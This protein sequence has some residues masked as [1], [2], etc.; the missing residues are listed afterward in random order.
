MIPNTAHALKTT[1]TPHY[2]S[3]RTHPMYAHLQQIE[4]LQTFMSHHVVA[5]WDFMS[6][7]KALQHAFTCTTWPWRPVGNPNIRRMLNEIVLA[8][9]SDLIDGKATSHFEYYCDAMRAIGANTAPIAHLVSALETG[10][11]LTEALVTTTLPPAAK[12]F[13]ETTLNILQTGKL[14][15]I[16]AAFALGR[17]DVIP[18]MFVQLVN[19]Q[20]TLAPEQV[21]MYKTYLDR[22]IALDGDDHGP[23]AMALLDALCGDNPDA[24]QDALDGA[25]QALEA[26]ILLWDAVYTQIA[27]KSPTS[28]GGT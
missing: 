14:P 18:D 17:E 5:V 21:A 8:E 12:A 27:Y 20:H 24:W 3:L 9:E 7:L 1:L 23:M 22:H 13:L 4:D 10:Q 26:R 15:A 28:P 6:L 2:D 16:A 25:T 11:T 19:Q